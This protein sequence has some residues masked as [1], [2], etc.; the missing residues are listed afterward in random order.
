M[1]EPFF[2]GP[3]TSGRWESKGNLFLPIPCVTHKRGAFWSTCSL[4]LHMCSCFSLSSLLLCSLFQIENQKDAGEPIAF[5]HMLHKVT[6]CFPLVR[7]VLGFYRCTCTW[8]APIKHL[9]NEWMNE[10][11]H[12]GVNAWIL[13]LA[14]GERLAFLEHRLVSP[15]P[16]IASLVLGMCSKMLSELI[17]NMFNLD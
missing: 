7:I 3:H 12:D 1:K 13:S 11:L 4:I 9:P 10:W 14:G 16:H 5:A 6:S 15:Q 17:W 2:A 8:Q